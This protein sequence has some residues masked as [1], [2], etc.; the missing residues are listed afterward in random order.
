MISIEGRCAWLVSIDGGRPAAFAKE[1]AMTSARTTTTRFALP[2]SVRTIETLALLVGATLFDV[3][4]PPVSA[5][6]PVPVEIEIVLP[7]SDPQSDSSANEDKGR[8]MV[9]ELYLSGGAGLT[10]AGVRLHFDATALA[11][12][13]LEDVLDRGL[14]GHQLKPDETDADGDPATDTYLNVAWADSGKRW[15]RDDGK[16]QLLLRALFRRTGARESFLRITSPALPPG[17]S[18][19]A[20]PVRVAQ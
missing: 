13:G 14:I 18:I 11:W 5:Q 20:L 15:P 17:R 10:G 9:V 7:Q 4:V 8:S 1:C 2:R 19:D 3:A 6:Q 16:R 12:L